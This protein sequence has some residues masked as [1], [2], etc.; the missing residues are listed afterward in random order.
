MPRK[1]TPFLP[2]QY[3]H[4]YNRGN[5]RQ[6]VFF[7]RDNYLYFLKSIKRYLRDYV[8]I[9]AYVLMPTHYHI[10]GRVRRLQTPRH[11]KSL[12]LRMSGVQKHPRR[13]RYPCK[14]LVFPTPRPSTNVSRVWVHYFKG[15][16]RASQY[17]VTSTCS[18]YAFTSIRTLLKDRLSQ[19]TRRVGILQLS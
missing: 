12:R 5:N 8:D 13:S 19:L 6:A 2:D 18:I 15:S 17:K 10:F 16:F 4:F 11:P 7:E 1:E 14:S 3:Y 9:L